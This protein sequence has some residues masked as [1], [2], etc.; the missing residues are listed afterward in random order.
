M[1][2]A[3]R[4]RLSY[5]N[6]VATGALFVALGGGAYALSGVPD[7]GGVFH[8][9][10]SNATALMRVVKSASSCQKPSTVRRKGRRVRLP[11]EFAVA[12]NQQGRQGAQGLQG[13]AGTNATVNGV[14]AGGDLTGTFPAPSIAAGVVGPS[15]LASLPMVKA[16]GSAS[17]VP[18]TTGTNLPFAANPSSFDFDTDG[19]HSATTNPERL[20]ARTRGTYLVYVLVSW[21]G[22]STGSTTGTRTLFLNDI[23]ADGGSQGTVFS[24]APASND[25]VQEGTRLV[26]MQPGD[27]VTVSAFQDSGAAQ[28]ISPIDFGAAWL[29]P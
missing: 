22:A 17:S 6:V 28:S 29:G 15:R 2:N 24:R 20:T 7:R 23:R 4:S 11:G 12:W 8:G 3:V 25:L 19:M 14:P 1:L 10:V 21:G 13:Q 9:C 18:N 27:F 26:H 5:A 16:P